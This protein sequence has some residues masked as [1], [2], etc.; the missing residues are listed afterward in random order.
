[1]RSETTQKQL[2]TEAELTFKR[3][4]EIAQAIEAAEKKSEQFKK[5]EHVEV[6]KL[7]H[8]RKP[9]QPCYRCGKL[10]HSSST[11]RFKEEMCRSCGKKGHIARVCRSKKQGSSGKG[12]RPTQKKTECTNWVGN[13]SEDSDSDLPVHKITASSTYPITVELEIQGKSVVME[14]DTGAAVSVISE[15][16]YKE[17]FPNLTL[18][19]VPMGLK[20]YTGEGIPVLGEVVVE[21]SYHEQNHQLS[22]I[23]VKG[24]GHNLFG[25]DWLMHFKL[26]WKTIGLTTLENAK[27]RV[28]LLLKKYEE[29][30]SSS[31]GA[32]KHFSAKLNVKEDARPIFLKPRSVPFAIREAIEAELKRLEAKGIIEKVP[33]SKWAAPIVSV[34]KG[35]GKI[36]I[37]GDY[38]VTIN[39]SLQV[40]QYPLP[41]PEDLFASLAGGEKFSKIDLT[42]A[43]LQLQLEEES[44]EF[45]TVN[46]SFRHRLSTCNFSEDDGHHIAGTESCTM[47]H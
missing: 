33:H 38:K 24:K 10:G 19:I 32:M 35:D 40:D 34:P 7:T 46:L 37:C 16:T 44:R 39:Q 29:V 11:C 5:A 41:K 14:V 25:R 36:R 15:T 1:M 42:Q 6:N 22:L 45:V 9:T 23:V 3:V 18:K 43:Y 47:L 17:L 2:L 4:V 12:R 13:E 21:V 28:D 20:T 31:R 27:A 26:H 30:F 8:N